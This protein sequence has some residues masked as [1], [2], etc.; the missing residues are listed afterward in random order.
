MGLFEFKRSAFLATIYKSRNF[1]GLF[2]HQLKQVQQQI[3]KSRNF[4][5]LFEYCCTIKFVYLQK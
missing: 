4:M 5:G 2:E 1:M 3:Y